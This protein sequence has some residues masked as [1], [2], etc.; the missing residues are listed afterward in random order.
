MN[1]NLSVAAY[2]RVSRDDAQG[3]SIVDQKAILSSYAR[4]HFPGCALTFFEDRTGCTFEQREG[5]QR[6]RRGLLDHRFDILLIKDFSRFSRR[7]IRSLME[8]DELRDAGVRIISVDEGVDFSTADDW[9]G[10]Q[11]RFLLEEMP[12]DKVV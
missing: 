3:V 2:C 12:S 6:M 1:Q 8:L 4:E 7:N 9:C 10:I 5:Y 11:F